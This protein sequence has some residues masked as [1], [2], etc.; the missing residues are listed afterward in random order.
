VGINKRVRSHSSTTDGEEGSSDNNNNNPPLPKK[1]REDHRARTMGGNTEPRHWHPA[2][3]SCRQDMGYNFQKHRHKDNYVHGSYS[4][5]NH[6]DGS[7]G[8]A[9]AAVAAT[10][11]AVGLQAVLLDSG[12]GGMSGQLRKSESFMKISFYCHYRNRLV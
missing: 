10:V 11:A 12:P 7:R 2:N 5:A 1:K 3:P 4:Q 8:A 9:V 6:Y